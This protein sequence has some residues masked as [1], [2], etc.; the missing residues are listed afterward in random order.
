MSIQVKEEVMPTGF[1]GPDVLTKSGLGGETLELFRRELNDAASRAA[2]MATDRAFRYADAVSRDLLTRVK[3]ELTGYAKPKAQ[4]LAVEVDAIRRKLSKPANSNLGWMLINAKLNLNTLL[5]G[6]AGCGK[7]VAAGQLSEAL[8]RPFGHAC[9]TAGASETWLFGR[10]TPTGFVEGGFSKLYRN[11]G[12]FLADEMDAADA[13]LLLAINTAL[14][15]GEMYNPISGEIIKR[16][17]DFSFVGG[18]N[19]VG[20]GGD[21]IYTGRSRL[22]AATLDRFVIIMVDYDPAI[23]EQVCPDQELREKLQ[24]A[25][26]KL[27][28]LN[29][30]E[31]ISTRGLERAYLLKNAGIKVEQIMASM[32]AGWP[33][34]L[35]EQS[36]LVAPKKKGAA[37]KGKKDE[38]PF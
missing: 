5:V 2:E 32:T 18:A 27:R 30:M 23:E 10:Q 35:A 8:G 24:A 12:V 6:P 1:A 15:N 11:G 13:N 26:A 14:A 28:E 3:D 33:E 21:A 19:T 4:I 7:T 38:L 37:G 20:R 17:A 22:D 29:A 34:E 31:V 9:M 16:H 36:G 25:R